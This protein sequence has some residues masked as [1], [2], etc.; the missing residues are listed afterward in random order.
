[1]RWW[2]QWQKQRRHCIIWVQIMRESTRER[3]YTYRRKN[4]ECAHRMLFFSNAV[5][6]LVSIHYIY[7]YI[8]HCI[9]VLCIWADNHH[10]F[11]IENN[12]KRTT[13]MAISF[14]EYFHNEME[15]VP[16]WFSQMRTSHVKKK[17]KLWLLISQSI[18]SY[19]PVHFQPF[20][21]TKTIN[22]LIVDN[23]Y[24]L[25]HSVLTRDRYTTIDISL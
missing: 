2:E 11:T 10:I 18:F 15:L 19:F 20:T 9:L 21:C 12:V 3:T 13:A 1:M 4:C 25:N 8:I 22:C 23:V 6:L 7:K 16:A 14:H 24:R 5:Q 17:Y